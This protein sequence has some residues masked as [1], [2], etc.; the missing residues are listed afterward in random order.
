MSEKPRRVSLAKEIK[1]RDIVG[2]IWEQCLAESAFCAFVLL[3]LWGYVV[4][5]TK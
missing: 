5:L 4:V 1:R 3:T 2:N